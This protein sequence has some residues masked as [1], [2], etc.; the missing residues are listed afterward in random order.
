MVAALAL[1]AGAVISHK[2]T[3][4]KRAAGASGRD[5]AARIQ[6]LARADREEAIFQAAQNGEAV[7]WPTT[8]VDGVGVVPWDYFAIGRALVAGD[9]EDDFLR[10]PC[11]G[12][13]ALRLAEL[14]GA[15]LPGP[16]DVDAIYNAAAVRLVGDGMGPPYDGSMMSVRRFVIYDTQTQHELARV[17]A[18]T[19]DGLRAGHRKDVLGTHPASYYGR[20][21]AEGERLA[22][23]GLFDAEG[24]PYQRDNGA[25]EASYAD[26]SHGVRLIT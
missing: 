22:F 15:R 17:L 14:F 26:G 2:L 12:P 1:G 7:A 6:D 3:A 25:H 21:S 16:S 4:P 8:T 20:P 19:A 11:S 24:Q 5:F 18:T 13:L 23:Y 9:E 10:M